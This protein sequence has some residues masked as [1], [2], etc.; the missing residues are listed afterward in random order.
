MAAFTVNSPALEKITWEKVDTLWK[1]REKV[2]V[3]K[4]IH[5][6]RSKY[7]SAEQLYFS[8]GIWEWG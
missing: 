1:V 3:T 6:L 5:L 4:R 7:V 2:N 8:V